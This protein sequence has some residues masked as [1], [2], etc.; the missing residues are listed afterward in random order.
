MLS[1]L[2]HAGE[3]EDLMPTINDE[4]VADHVKGLQ[5]VVFG[6]VVEYVA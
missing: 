6:A 4:P 5:Q 3:P 1:R 2:V